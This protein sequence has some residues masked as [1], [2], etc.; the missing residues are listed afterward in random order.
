MV[1]KIILQIINQ[2]QRMQGLDTWII[3]EE[4]KLTI[5]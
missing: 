5:I 4:R 1:K 3:P 2:E